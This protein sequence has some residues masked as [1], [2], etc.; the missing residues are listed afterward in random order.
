MIFGDCHW[1]WVLSIEELD[2]GVPFQM[3]RLALIAVVLVRLTRVQGLFKDQ[4][5]DT[6][7]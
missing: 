3:E 7:E 1:N 5:G 6:K 4:L 2:E